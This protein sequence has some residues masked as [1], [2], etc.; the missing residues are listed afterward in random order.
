LRRVVKRVNERAN[1]QSDCPPTT[2]TTCWVTYLASYCAKVRCVALVTVSR[3]TPSV[4]TAGERRTTKRQRQRNSDEQQQT[5]TN[6]TTSNSERNNEQ[7]NKSRRAISADTDTSVFVQFGERK[8]LH[9]SG[10]SSNFVMPKCQT[11]SIQKIYSFD[12]NTTR[13]E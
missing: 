2:S 3:P 9:G 7:R 6:E 5:T 1:E 4:R 8:A 12:N 10:S 13:N 11:C